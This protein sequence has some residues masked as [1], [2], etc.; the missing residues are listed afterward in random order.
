MNMLH[1]FSIVLQWF[2]FLLQFDA[3]AGKQFKNAVAV[4]CK[5]QAY[6]LETLKN[7]TR[8]D[9]KLAAFLAVS[10]LIF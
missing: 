7:K 3:D 5:N 2:V 1:D 9:Q 6:A 4:F 8:K 10:M